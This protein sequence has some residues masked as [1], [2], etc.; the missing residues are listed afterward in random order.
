MLEGD[1]RVRIANIIESVKQ[2]SADYY[3]LTGKPLGVTGEVAEHTAA[4]LLDLEL[5]PAR[6]SGFDAIRRVNGRP[7]K[8]QIKGR[9]VDQ[10]PK[11]GQRLGTIKKDAD[12]DIVM[13]VLLSNATLEPLEISEASMVVVIEL[14]E[15]TNS[16]ARARGSLAIT[17]FKKRARKV[18]P[19]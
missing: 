17:T 12:C 16:K 13:L 15:E 1:L 3:T 19:I 14:L 4:E 18:W 10:K 7:E 2:L 9:A 5:A 6:T 8:I 11:A